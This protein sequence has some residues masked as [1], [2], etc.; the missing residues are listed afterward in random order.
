MIVVILG[1]VDYHVYNVI[2]IITKV[3]VILDDVDYHVYNVII[4]ITK[5]EVILAD[6]WTIM[7]IM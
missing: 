2:I 7:F 3:E 5:V 6:V 4:I 1:D